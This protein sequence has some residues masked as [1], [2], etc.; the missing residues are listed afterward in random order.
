M[1]PTVQQTCNI[2]SYSRRSESQ[3]V[4][5]QKQEGNNNTDRHRQT[6]IGEEQKSQAEHQEA[7]KLR[8]NEEA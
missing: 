6:L 8:P 1:Y 5:Y 7:D 4:E 2:K 3:Q